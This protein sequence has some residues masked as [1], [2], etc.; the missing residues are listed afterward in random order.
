VKCT[1]GATVGQLDDDALFYIRS[2]GVGE[3]AA[4]NMLIHA[5]ASEVVSELKRVQL[6]HHLEERLLRKLGEQV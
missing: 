3:A 2:R 6:R 5:F 1:H 4:R